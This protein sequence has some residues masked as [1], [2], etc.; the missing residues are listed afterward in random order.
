[1]PES[2]IAQAIRESLRAMEQSGAC[3]FFAAIQFVSAIELAPD[4]K[5]MP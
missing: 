2:T 1:M 3:E 5:T 4:P